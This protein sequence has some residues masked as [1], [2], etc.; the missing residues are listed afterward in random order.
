MF[1]AEQPIARL[2]RLVL[3]LLKDDAVGA[4]IGAVAS[5]KA[6][7]YAFGGMPRD[8][9]FSGPSYFGDIDIFVSGR[10]DE[11]LLSSKGKLLGRTNFGGLRYVVG[12]YDV[13][14]WEL[15]RSRAF[16][17]GQALPVSVQSLLST[18]C[19]ST[20]AVAISFSSRKIL[21][22]HA[23]WRSLEA[24]EIDFVRAPASR[25][26]LQA[27][28]AARAIV[29]H[30][31]SPSVA[32]ANYLDSVIGEFGSDAILRAEERWGSRR[33]L[34][35]IAIDLVC[36]KVNDVLM[37][38]ASQATLGSKPMRSVQNGISPIASSLSD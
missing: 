35:R 38:G 24:R 26:V 19:F 23:F 29:K 17:G 28:R 30:G 11:G 32:V 15:E 6:E 27:T 31:L 14:I 8:V 25:D 5:T 13:D 33:C 3:A 10:L 7:A 12:G 21:A 1:S 2:R 16:A 36:G 9:L 37:P 22:S 20:D 4:F 34:E 18:V